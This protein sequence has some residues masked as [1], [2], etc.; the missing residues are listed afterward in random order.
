MD[1]P[2][3]E[4]LAASISCVSDP[5]FRN[6]LTR[7]PMAFR[8]SPTRKLRLWWR[9][10]LGLRGEVSDIPLTL[11]K[12][13]KYKFVPA[14]NEVAPNAVGWRKSEISQAAFS[15]ICSVQKSAKCPRSYRI[16]LSC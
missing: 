2:K 11:S 8:F 1:Q 12:P 10:G 3:T 7:S 5:I 4:H 6:A 13:N 14:N 16:L 15:Q 9:T